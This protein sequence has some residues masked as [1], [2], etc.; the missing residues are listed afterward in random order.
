VNKMSQNPNYFFPF[1][2]CSIA[3]PAIAHFDSLKSA[4]VA[5]SSPSS[6]FL[7]FFDLF[8]RRSQNLS[9]TPIQQ[10]PNTHLWLVLRHSILLP[11]CHEFF[12]GILQCRDLLLCLYFLLQNL[13]N[14]FSSDPSMDLLNTFI[15][16][17]FDYSL[18]CY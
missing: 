6:N 9:K 18:S 13:V 10:A 4:L 3:L 17:L 11:V 2:H 14:C 1:T 8:W 15:N 5:R 7:L 12:Q 16:C